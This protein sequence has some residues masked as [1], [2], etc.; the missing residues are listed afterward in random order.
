LFIL[1]L[2]VALTAAGAG[3]QV[4]LPTTVTIY[5]MGTFAE[6]AMIS[7]LA[8]V[9]NKTTNGELLLSP[10]NGNLPNPRYWLDRLKEQYPTVQS[11]VQSNTLL[12]LNKYK[13]KVS[14]YVLYDRS[15]N[16]HSLNMATSIAGVTN[17]I[18]V[19]PSTQLT[20]N[21]AGLPMIA[22][23]RSMTYQQVYNTYAGQFNKDML[24][25]QDLYFDHHLRDY[26]IQNKIF[27]YFTDPTALNPTGQPA[28]A[29]NQNHQ[30][31]IFGWANSEFDLFNQ[32]S[33]SNQQAV[34]SNYGWSYSTTSKWKVPIAA[35]K[36]HPPG[37]VT[38]KTG[39]HYV[40]FVMSDGDN[41][42][43]LTN[44]P[45]KIQHDLGFHAQLG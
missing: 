20:A 21:I 7:S 29:S 1:G 5:P 37:S 15:V 12:L 19:D 33:Q 38:T 42:Q 24:L 25:H 4:Q 36:Y 22:D 39:K 14:G 27:T 23:A 45:G 43:W 13:S 17:A 40:A 16:P 8:G 34:A 18:I 28:Y 9:V 44:A 30:G 32:A 2:L 3:A 35:Q 10:D 26:A 31:R 6:N 11:Q 41:T